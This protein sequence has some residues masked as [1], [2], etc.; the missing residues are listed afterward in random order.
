MYRKVGAIC[1]LALLMSFASLVL[2]GPIENR[3]F[4]HMTGVALGM[5]MIV[6]AILAIN[7][8]RE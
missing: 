8:G 5:V 7:V 1:L 4:S 2:G 3:D 6:D